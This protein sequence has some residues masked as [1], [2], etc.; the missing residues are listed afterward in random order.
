MST[1]HWI[2]TAL[3]VLILIAIIVGFIYEPALA[4][5]ERKRGEKMLKAFNERK[6]LRK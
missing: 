6:K 2:Q 1:A 4:E 3:E 5:W